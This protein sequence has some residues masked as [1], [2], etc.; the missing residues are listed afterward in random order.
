M[1]AEYREHPAKPLRRAGEDLVVLGEGEETVWFYLD[2]DDG[3]EGLLA[4]RLDG[5]RARICAVPVFAYGVA[6]GD[7]VVVE[8]RDGAAVATALVRE[9]GNTT[10]RVIF[11]RHGAP[12]PDERWRSLLADLERHGCWIDVYS[13][14][15]VAV[16][17]EP[18]AVE[19][20]AAYLRGREERGELAHEAG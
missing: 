3:W 12:E 9:A 14:Q 16:S 13:P 5:G 18:R 2:A 8:D 20:V 11:P 15:L 6:L 7:E 17:A 19:D 10:F 1:P 4:R